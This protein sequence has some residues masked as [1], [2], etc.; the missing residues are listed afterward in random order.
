MRRRIG[1]LSTSCEIHAK[2]FLGF[3]KARRRTSP[4]DRRTLECVRVL[5]VRIWSFVS[6]DQASSGSGLSE[7]GGIAV[8][9]AAW[10]RKT[11]RRVETVLHR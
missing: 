6:L 4:S 7:M 11:G 2:C 8:A 9:V 10:R 5:A 3:A 1:L